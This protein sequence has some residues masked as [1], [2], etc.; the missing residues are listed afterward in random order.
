M[1]S[2]IVPDLTARDPVYAVGRGA[3]SFGIREITDDGLDDAFPER[4]RLRLLMCECQLSVSPRY[5]SNALPTLPVAPVI[6]ISGVCHEPYPF[7]GSGPGDEALP[8]PALLPSMG[9][10]TG[11]GCS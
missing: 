3:D 2:Q 4:P 5:S 6:R 7:V 9:Q 1:R 10:E 8:A 11:W